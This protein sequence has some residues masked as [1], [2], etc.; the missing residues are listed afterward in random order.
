[1]IIGHLECKGKDEW[2]S[3]CRNVFVTGARGRGRGK[4]TGEE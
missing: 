4:K 3:A 1:M 2:V